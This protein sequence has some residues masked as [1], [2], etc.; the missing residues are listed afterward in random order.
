[1][2]RKFIPLVLMAAAASSVIEASP[3]FNLSFG[4]LALTLVSSSIDGGIVNFDVRGTAF[5]DVADPGP[6]GAVVVTD[7][8]IAPINQPSPAFPNHTMFALNTAFSQGGFLNFVNPTAAGGTAH[9]DTTFTPAFGPILDPATIAFAS[10][11]LSITFTQSAAPVSFGGSTFS[12]YDATSLAAG[13]PAG[14]GPPV[15]PPPGGGVPEPSTYTMLASGLLWIGLYVRSK[16]GH[17]G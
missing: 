14:A 7:G 1:M 2:F 13:G 17:Q 11:P 3:L 15:P 10:Q 4:G 5:A 9:L 12:F 8:T 6:L 16:R